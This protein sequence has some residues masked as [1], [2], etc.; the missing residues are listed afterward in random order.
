MAHYDPVEFL[1][2]VHSKSS[3]SSYERFQNLS[4]KEG[5]IIEVEYIN[6]VMPYVTKP[7]LDHNLDNHNPVIPFVENCPS[8]GM[9]IILSDSG[10]TAS[11]LNPMCPERVIQRMANMMDKLG[12]KDFAEESMRKI[13]VT[14]LTQLMNLTREELIPILGDINSYKLIE[15]MNLL[16]T[17]PIYDFT[18]VGALGFTGIAQETWKKIF[19][20]YTLKEVMNLRFTTSDKADEFRNAILGIKGIGQNTEETIYYEMM[21]TNFFE[22]LNTILNMPN[23]ISSKGLT[24]KKIRCT[25]FRDGELMEYLRSLGY[26]ADDNKSVT[27]D[28]Y[29]LLIPQEG[30]SSSKTKSA[31]PNTLILPVAEFR[32]NM[33]KYI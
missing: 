25:G 19:N 6:D 29:I 31:G 24:Q 22:D 26:D 5:D 28:T 20:V 13:N 9:E 2:T 21:S 7:D 8:C 18:I 1:G 17:Q 33:A 23:V 4:L 27:K 3:V 14:S 30:H 16:K 11:C 10:K 12:L 32:E 15:R